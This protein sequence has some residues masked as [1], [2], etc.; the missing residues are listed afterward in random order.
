VYGDVRGLKVDGK[1]HP[2]NRTY[3]RWDV[4]AGTVTFGA[5]SLDPDA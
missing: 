2:N 3:A 1:A 5:R 4:H